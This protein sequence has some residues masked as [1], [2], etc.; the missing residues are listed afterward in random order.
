MSRAS[1][2]IRK[3]SWYPNKKIETTL[4]TYTVSPTPKRFDVLRPLTDDDQQNEE[5]SEVSSNA[6][7]LKPGLGKPRTSVRHFEGPSTSIFGQHSNQSAGPKQTSS[8]GLSST[9]RRHTIVHP[10][11]TSLLLKPIQENQIEDMMDM[12]DL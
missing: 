10:D 8:I 2:D 3:Y 6:S 9:L 5:V 11:H 1:L 7:A 4:S 12:M